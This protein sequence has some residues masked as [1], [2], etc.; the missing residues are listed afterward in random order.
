[1]VQQLAWSPDRK[2]FAGTAN[3]LGVAWTIGR[4]NAGTGQIN[5]V[6]E[7]DRYNCT[8][9]WL[10]DSER[11]IYS[12]GIV[13]DS[14]GWAQLWVTAG[15]GDPRRMLYAEDG[16]HIY[17]GCVS[18]DGAYVLFTRSKEDLG[19]VDNSQTTMAIVRWKDTPM[20]GRGSE[21]LRAD[22][23]DARSGPLLDLSWGWEPHWT[24]NQTAP[25]AK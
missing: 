13:P 23:L 15:G 22:Y 1:V 17:G 9:D 18:P 8:P 16:R 24:Y 20:V 3:G 19:K 4:L 12:R 7:T 11:I 6:S 10:A 5:A 2:W 21:S 14:A 25:A